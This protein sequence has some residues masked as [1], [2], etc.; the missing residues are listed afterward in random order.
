M[1]LDKSHTFR[2]QMISYAAGRAPLELLRYYGAPVYELPLRVIRAVYDSAGDRSSV[3]GRNPEEIVEQLAG[4]RFNELVLRYEPKSPMGLSWGAKLKFMDVRMEVSPTSELWHPVPEVNNI[5]SSRNARNARSTFQ[6]LETHVTYHGIRRRPV[7]YS[8]YAT[9]VPERSYDRTA[10][11]GGFCSA[12]DA[13]K[14][15][16][17]IT[18]SLDVGNAWLGLPVLK[19]VASQPKSQELL[20]T[21]F[22][23]LHNGLFGP[24]AICKPLAEAIGEAASLRSL[25]PISGEPMGFVEIEQAA[26][27]NKA[28]RQRAAVWLIEK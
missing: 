2:V 4:R 17:P 5:R 19:N 23:E 8:F 12:L 25:Q 14:L 21:H 13:L 9:F 3:R 22:D 18:G 24:M 26:I 27:F 15:S 7:V 10:I 1:E 11:I 16:F 28:V 20:D 6:S